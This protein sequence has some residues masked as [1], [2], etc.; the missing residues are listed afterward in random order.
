MHVRIVTDAQVIPLF[1]SLLC[2]LVVITLIRNSELNSID[3]M[4]QPCV[5]LILILVRIIP[6]GSS[7]ESHL[8]P[9]GGP[10]HVCCDRGA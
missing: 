4:L 6:I 9:Y 10:W 1:N 5:I 7:Y 2:V 8:P 3:R